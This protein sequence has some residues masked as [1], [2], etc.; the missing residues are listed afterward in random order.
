MKRSKLYYR[1]KQYGILYTCVLIVKAIIRKLFG[2]SWT[3]YY[4][5]CRRTSANDLELVERP[6]IEIRKLQ[7]EDLC[8]SP[9]DVFFNSRKMEI[10]KA[11]INNNNV[12]GFGI[13]LKNQLVYTSWI[14]YEKFEIT[15]STVL[16]L[17]A[18]SALL[19]DSFCHPDYR[20]QGFHSIMNKFRIKRIYE[21]G[22]KNVYGLVLKHNIPAIKIQTKC[23]LKTKQC[24]RVFKI[25]K[26]EYC[27]L[28]EIKQP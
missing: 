1:A 9:C 7:M 16:S 21:R 11:R 2:V 18:Q 23:G 14:N 3:L 17:P 19:L 27:T 12:E 15:T 20:K 26:K 28:K 5:M 10:F 24:L 22:F 25:G 8:N 6:D 13:F 4:V